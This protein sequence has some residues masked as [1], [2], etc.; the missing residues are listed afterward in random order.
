MEQIS[1]GPLQESE[2]PEAVVISTCA[3]STNPLGVRRFVKS[4]RIRNAIRKTHKGG[5]W[6]ICQAKCSS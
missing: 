1:I 6:G 4:I 5:S 3:Y 2:L